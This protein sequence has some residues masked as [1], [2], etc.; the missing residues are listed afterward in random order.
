MVTACRGGTVSREIEHGVS[1]IRV[2]VDTQSAIAQGQF[3][4]ALRTPVAKYSRSLD[5]TTDVGFVRTQ[6][7]PADLRIGIVIEADRMLQID[8]GQVETHLGFRLSP[9]RR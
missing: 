8:Q 4:G 7:T 2:G 3:P 9:Q 5:M 1:A 6:F